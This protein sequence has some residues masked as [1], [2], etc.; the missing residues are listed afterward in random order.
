[1]FD[2]MNILDALLKQSSSAVVLAV[3]KVFIDLTSNRLDLQA[4]TL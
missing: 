4:T 1:M 3:T 2:I